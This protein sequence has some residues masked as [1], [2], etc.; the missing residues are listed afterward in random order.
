MTATNRSS[1][2]LRSLWG[3]FTLGQR[4]GL[5][6]SG[7]LVLVGLLALVIWF[8]TASYTVLFG[9]LPPE[10]AAEIIEKLDTYDVSYRLTD[11]GSVVQV[12]AGRVFELRMRL[13]SQSTPQSGA[14]GYGLF[15]ELAFTGADFAQRT[16]YI[17]ALEA[18]LT[19]TIRGIDEVEGARVHLAVSGSAFS[20][21]EPKAAT[22]SVVLQMRAGS[23]LGSTQA[24]GV[25]FL[26]ASSVP[27]LAPASVTIADVGGNVLH[28][29]RG[30]SG[31][32]L[33]SNQ[34]EHK[35][36]FERQTQM[37]IRAMIERVFG[38]GIAVV[39]VSARFNFDQVEQ[40]AEVFDPDGVVVKSTSSGKEGKK[41]SYE[42][43][44][45]V[46]R[47]VKSPGQLERMRIDVVVDGTYQESSESGEDGQNGKKTF[48]PRSAEE[49]DRIGALV[50]KVAEID[51]LRGDRLE[52]V[53][54]PFKPD[55]TIE[56]FD[57]GVGA[58]FYLVLVKYGI[59]LLAAIFFFT[60]LF[61]PFVSLLGGGDTGNALARGEIT[62]PV[63]LER[64]EREMG[65]GDV[66]GGGAQ[67]YQNGDALPEDARKRDALKK[68]LI[69]QIE[70][71]PEAA[72][73]LIRSWVTE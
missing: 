43:S 63:S 67:T 27:G 14:V 59:G 6:G 53:C 48:V 1:G 23:K 32:A 36:N 17:R 58:G 69:E 15:D 21:Q 24:R 52:I 7:A 42:V 66:Q 12:P 4:T 9:N 30:A 22:A 55:E 34:F 44:R 19:R 60:A 8:S 49:L 64:L 13:A 40:T 37:R 20:E 50:K 70:G 39:H 31:A 65:L 16:S 68:E 2:L 33:A 51:P 38:V 61:R 18:E 3:G 45:T 54:I 73:S 10:D 35:S 28:L 62:T 72:A 29:D 26:V 57:A 5:V 46:T 47:T 56:L 41:V 11:G 71:E 25:A